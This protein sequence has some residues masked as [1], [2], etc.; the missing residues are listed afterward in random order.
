MLLLEEGGIPSLSHKSL[1]L[2]NS[3]LDCLLHFTWPRSFEKPIDLR[4]LGKNRIYSEPKSDSQPPH[5]VAHNHIHVTPTLRYPRPSLYSMGPVHMGGVPYTYAGIY[6]IQNKKKFLFRKP[7]S[8]RLKVPFISFP[9][10]S[11]YPTF[12]LL[13]NPGGKE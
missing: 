2:L 5:P 11:P 8:K 4:I 3:S 1:K 13:R 10:R 6:I 7:E 12:L 9:L